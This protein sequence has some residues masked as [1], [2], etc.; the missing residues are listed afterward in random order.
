MAL[1]AAFQGAQQSAI[2]LDALVVLDFV[3]SSGEVIPMY[4]RA[5]RRAHVLLKWL[6]A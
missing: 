1:H 2:E 5:V 3:S 4:A 6:P